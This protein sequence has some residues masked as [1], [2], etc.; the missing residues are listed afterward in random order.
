MCS[1]G[2]SLAPVLSKWGLHARVLCSAAELTRATAGSAV[3][4]STRL[5]AL[6]AHHRAHSSSRTSM[7]AV[8]LPGITSVVRPVESAAMQEDVEAAV[9]LLGPSPESLLVLEIVP[10]APTRHGT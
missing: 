4:R 8:A 6:F 7:P 10:S 5:D 9:D 3:G 1:V 2:R